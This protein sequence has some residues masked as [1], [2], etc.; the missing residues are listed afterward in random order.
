MH[1]RTISWGLHWGQIVQTQLVEREY[2]DVGE[3][4]KHGQRNCGEIYPGELHPIGMCNPI[5]MDIFST[6][7][8]GHR[9]F[10]CRSGEDD[11]RNLF[12]SYF[13]RKYEDPLPRRRSSKYNAGQ[14]IRNG[15]LESSDVISGEV[16][17]LHAREHITG[18]GRDGRGG[19]LQCRPPPDPK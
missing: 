1:G 2:A 8:L 11:S 4:Y 6:R 17:K 13:I 16:L 10:V 5:R 3:E 14:E 12:A 15:T 18:M 9:R 19:I 7:Y